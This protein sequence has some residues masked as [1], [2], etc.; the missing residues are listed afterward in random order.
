MVVFS[1][2][3]FA[4][5][6][7]SVGKTPVV[8]YP[9]DPV[10]GSVLMDVV[11][12]SLLWFENSVSTPREKSVKQINCEPQPLTILLSLERATNTEAVTKTRTD[13]KGGHRSCQ[14]HSSK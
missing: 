6:V 11:D 13:F 1:V 4:V 2:V 12:A 7:K 14:S 5:V 9:V 10:T 3:A 8:V